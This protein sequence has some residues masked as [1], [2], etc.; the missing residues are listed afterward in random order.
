MDTS[1]IESRYIWG[2]KGWSNDTKIFGYWREVIHPSHILNKDFSLLPLKDLLASFAHNPLL[3]AP[4]LRALHLRV[5]QLEQLVV[6]LLSFIDDIHH[7]HLY[8]SFVLTLRGLTALLTN[9][10]SNFA[11]KLEIGRRPL[12]TLRIIVFDYRL[13][14][15]NRPRSLFFFI[16]SKWH[17]RIFV[18]VKIT[19]FRWLL[20]SNEIFRFGSEGFLN[21]LLVS[22]TVQW[23]IVLII[24]ESWGWLLRLDQV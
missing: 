10:F 9:I 4:F 5:L 2:V 14:I 23:F 15:V 13:Y 18:S 12:F 8:F 6:Q 21:I 22:L 1:W 7:F 24:G 3:L 16:L 20:W 17:I 19:F 11:W